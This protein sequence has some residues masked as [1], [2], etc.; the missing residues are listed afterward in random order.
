MKLKDIKIGDTIIL[1]DGFP[2]ADP[3]PVKVVEGAYGKLGFLC[4]EG[5]HSLDG[6]EDSNGN[7]VGVSK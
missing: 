1:D 2:C 3:G 7:L 6:Q 5:F 4:S